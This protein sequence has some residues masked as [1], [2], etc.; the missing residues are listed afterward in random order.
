MRHL[1]KALKA[2]KNISTCTYG[3]SILN[4]TGVCAMIVVQIR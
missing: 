3:H 4:V 1:A 2:N